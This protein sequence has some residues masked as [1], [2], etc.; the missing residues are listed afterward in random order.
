[1]EL[2]LSSWVAAFNSKKKKYNTVII[3]DGNYTKSIPI[4]YFTADYHSI[5]VKH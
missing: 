5:T 1:M 2:E 4:F 3:Q